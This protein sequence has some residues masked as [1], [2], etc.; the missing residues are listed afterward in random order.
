MKHNEA[1]K[2]LSDISLPKFQML[3]S[4][5]TAAESWLGTRNRNTA[6]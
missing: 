2:H 6:K 5:L 3:T 4:D 1:W